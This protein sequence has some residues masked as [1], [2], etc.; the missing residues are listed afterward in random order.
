ML[1]RVSFWYGRGVAAMA[2]FVCVHDHRAQHP[3]QSK[4]DTDASGSVFFSQSRKRFAR[5]F[6]KKESLSTSEA[7]YICR[8]TLP[9]SSV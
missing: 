9:R 1:F 4:D 6:I 5:I 7:V 3:L 2:Y 8:I